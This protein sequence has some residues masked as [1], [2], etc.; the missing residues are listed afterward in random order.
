LGRAAVVLWLGEGPRLGATC[1]GSFFPPA[2]DSSRGTR[3]WVGDAM[4]HRLTQPQ[5]A[6]LPTSIDRSSPTG[7]AEPAATPDAAT[8]EDPNPTRP[9]SEIPGRLGWA[10]GSPVWRNSVIRSAYL[11]VATLL[12]IAAFA[13]SVSDATGVYLV[14]SADLG[15]DAVTAERLQAIV[16]FLA[17][18]MFGYLAISLLVGAAVRRWATDFQFAD[19]PM[20]LRE[21]EYEARAS[22]IAEVARCPARRDF[23]RVARE[24]ADTLELATTEGSRVAREIGLSVQADAASRVPKRSVPPYREVVGSVGVLAGTDAGGIYRV[25]PL[26]VSTLRASFAASLVDAVRERWPRIRGVFWKETSSMIATMVGS[27]LE[28]RLRVVQLRGIQRGDLLRDGVD[29]ADELAEHLWSDPAMRESALNSLSFAPEEAMPM[30]AT[31]ADARL[32]DS[33]VDGA[34]I[35][36]VPATLESLIH[37]RAMAPGSRVVVTDALETATALRVFPFKE[38]LY[39][40]VDFTR[41]REASPR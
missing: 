7:E 6:G 5:A 30:L 16:T 36:A 33:T 32:L 31:P 26:Y 29:P 8:T 17:I 19:V 25:Y 35:L 21:L 14:S 13:E 28:A 9:V 22:A 20:V 4:N 23:A 10:L 24:A 12:L 34:L 2:T 1:G 3:R 40:M 39:D 15:L 18:A 27:S 11:S 37:H 41:T 38:G